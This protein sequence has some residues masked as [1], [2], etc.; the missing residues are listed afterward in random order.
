VSHGCLH[1]YPEDI[2]RLFRE[3]PIGTPVR[4]VSQEVKA[5]W[6]GDALYIQVHPSKSQAEEI[7]VMGSFTPEMPAD[8][9]RR[10]TGAVG[11]RTVQVDWDA[12]RRAGIE[13]TGLPVRVADAPAQGTVGAR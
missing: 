7:D 3:I 5:A 12:V 1:L 11:D 9:A 13:R 8:L 10:V 2:E 4:V 6:V